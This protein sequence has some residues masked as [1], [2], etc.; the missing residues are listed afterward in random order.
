VYI[1][2]DE[3]TKSKDKR[4][5]KGRNISYNFPPKPN[6]PVLKKVD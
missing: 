3:R 1:V 2:Y 4:L 6:C 5:E